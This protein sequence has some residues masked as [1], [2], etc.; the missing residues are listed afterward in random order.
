MPFGAFVELTPSK[1][2]LLHISE[3]S[4]ERVEDVSSVFSVGDKV[5]VKVIKVDRQG[6]IDV[7]KKAL[8]KNNDKNDINAS[9]KKT[10]ISA[11]SSRKPMRKGGRKPVAGN[12]N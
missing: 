9:T 11:D 5:E 10:E 1:Q 2:G 4:K 6:R 7:S 3:I 12:D 8:L